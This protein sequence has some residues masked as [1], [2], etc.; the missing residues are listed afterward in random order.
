VELFELVGARAAGASG[1][2]DATA[3]QLMAVAA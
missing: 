1:T 2:Q 3:R